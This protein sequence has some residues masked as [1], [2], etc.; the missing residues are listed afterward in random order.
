[1]F[2]SV[3]IIMRSDRWIV[4]LLVREE[5]E[6]IDKAGTLADRNFFARQLFSAGQRCKDSTVITYSQANGSD[7]SMWGEI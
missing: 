4:F 3:L 7:Q 6:R 1:M 5:T 2:F